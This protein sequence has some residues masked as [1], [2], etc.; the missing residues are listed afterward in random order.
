[1]QIGQKRARLLQVGRIEALRKP[2]VQWCKEVVGFRTPTLGLPQT[3]QN[4]GSAQLEAFRL[5][6]ARD[7]NGFAEGS[8]GGGDVGIGR[9]QGNNT[10]NAVAFSGPNRMT[11]A[12]RQLEGFLDQRLRF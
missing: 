9:R 4:G 6:D 3:S 8:L 5:L 10:R 2:S 11:R 1:M 12:M 7:L